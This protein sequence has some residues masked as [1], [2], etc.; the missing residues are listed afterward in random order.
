VETEAKFG[1]LNLLRITAADGGHVIGIDDAT[2]EKIYIAIEFNSSRN[3]GGGGNSGAI[4][5]IATELA[6][7]A[8]IVNSEDDRNVFHY[9]IVAIRRTEEKGNERGLPIVAMNHVGEPDVFSDING[10]PGKFTEAFGIVREIARGCAVDAVAIE[11]GGIVNKEI[12]NAVEKS[13]VGNGG[14]SQARAERNCKAWHHHGGGFR[15]TVTGKNHGDLVPT[16]DQSFGQRFDYVGE[17]ARFG[18]RQAFGCHEQDSH[19]IIEL[20][21]RYRSGYS[22]SSEERVA[23]LAYTY[24]K[25]LIGGAE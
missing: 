2:F 1:S 16:G 13:A 23:R 19:T 21:L 12:V 5:R 10:G 9:R 14:K 4:H 11:V 22:A 25:K 7:I 15:A 18:K 6:L 17:A 8:H 24:A 3:E 20:E